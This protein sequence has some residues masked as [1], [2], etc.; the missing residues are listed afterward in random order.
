MKRKAKIFVSGLAVALMCGGIYLQSSA[1]KQGGTYN[2]WNGIDCCK[3]SGS[4]LVF[5]HC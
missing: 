1:Q 5:D 2:K 3:G 4:C